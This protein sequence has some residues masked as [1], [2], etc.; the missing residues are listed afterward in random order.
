MLSV[1]TKLSIEGQSRIRRAVPAG[2]PRSTGRPR[3]AN[4]TSGSARADSGDRLIAGRRRSSWYRHRGRRRCLPRRRRRRCSRRARSRCIP[5]SRSGGR[6]VYTSP[7]SRARPRPHAVLRRPACE[8]CS[9]VRLDGVD[10]DVEGIAD[11]ALRHRGR[12]EPQYL[13]LAIAELFTQRGR[14]ASGQTG[15]RAR[16]VP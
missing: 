4:S 2:Q 3:R 6:G 15:V 10:R 11:L 12:E 14:Q 13:E 8:R 16:R 9:H 7:R 5:C 1:R